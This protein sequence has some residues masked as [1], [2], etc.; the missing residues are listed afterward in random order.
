MNRHA[1]AIAYLSVHAVPRTLDR[2]D[3]TGMSHI[4]RS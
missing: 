4:R 1:L 3:T 2:N